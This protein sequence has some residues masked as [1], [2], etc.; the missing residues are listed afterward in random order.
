M[1]IAFFRQNKVTSVSNV[2]HCMLSP[3]YI[4]FFLSF[5][6]VFIF[7]TR[8]RLCHQLYVALLVDMSGPCSYD[9]S[10]ERKM[11]GYLIKSLHIYL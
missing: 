3:L 10:L 4:V 6:Y 8:Y 2:L 7:Q 9:S 1:A 11:Y 5:S